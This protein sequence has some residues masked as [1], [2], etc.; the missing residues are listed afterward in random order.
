MDGSSYQENILTKYHVKMG[1]IVTIIASLDSYGSNGEEI[2][3]DGP[4]TYMDDNGMKIIRLAYVSPFIYGHFL[5]K[6]K[7]LYSKL[8]EEQPDIIFS[9]NLQFGDTG[10][11]AKYLKKHPYVKLYADNHGDYINSARNWISRVIKHQIIWKHYVKKLEPFLTKV[12]GVTPMRCRFLREIYHIKPE[13][14]D[15][16]PLGVDDDEIPANRNEI[17][18][19]IRKELGLKSGEILMM[20]G[21]KIEP[22][23]N[24]NYLND[25]I[26][27]LKNRNLH[28]VVCGTFTSDVSS[29]EEKMKVNKNIHLLGWCDAKRVMEVMVA[30]DFVCF[31]GTH[32]TL[33]EQAVGLGL[34]AIFKK[35]N[36]IDQVNVNGNCIFVKGDNVNEI[37]RAINLLCSNESYQHYKKLSE[38]ASTSFLYSDIAK[39]SIS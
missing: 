1:N 34:P 33:W 38:D 24:T 27:L 25:A 23:K 32:S 20:T 5:M 31:P 15:F 11:V 12:Y 16:L 19:K 2:I 29:L 7:G 4:R 21:G 3:L 30:S 10:I 35:W 36:E 9:H 13:L 22:R 26:N 39:K 37:A 28:L 6:F 8:E 17:K 18:T 14:I